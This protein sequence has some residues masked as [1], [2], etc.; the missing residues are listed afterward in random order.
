MNPSRQQLLQTFSEP[1]FSHRVGEQLNLKRQ[2]EILFVWVEMR[3]CVPELGMKDDGGSCSA[4]CFA[5]DPVTCGQRTRSGWRQRN[6]PVQ[7]SAVWQAAS[8]GLSYPAILVAFA[9]F[10]LLAAWSIQAV[11]FAMMTFQMFF[12]KVYLMTR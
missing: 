5:T 3:L 8:V 2:L 12:A 10:L 9:L 7:C 4:E 11:I 1:P 6:Y